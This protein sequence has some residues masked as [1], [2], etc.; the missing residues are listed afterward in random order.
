MAVDTIA[1]A[2]NLRRRFGA[3][4]QLRLA[5]HARAVAICGSHLLPHSL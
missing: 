5:L 4:R 2:H 1:A 3:E